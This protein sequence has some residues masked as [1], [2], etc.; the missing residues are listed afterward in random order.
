M[1]EIKDTAEF[2]K[3]LA[4]KQEDKHNSLENIPNIDPNDYLRIV[5]SNSRY[6]PQHHMKTL[7]Q[8]ISQAKMMQKFGYET[9]Q[10][11][12]IDGVKQWYTHRDPRGCFM[13]DDQQFISVLVSLLEYIATIHPNLPLSPQ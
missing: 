9:S 10:R 6:A 2:Y 13:C 12:H 1:T 3:K 8:Y 5:R 7:E 4:Q 11:T